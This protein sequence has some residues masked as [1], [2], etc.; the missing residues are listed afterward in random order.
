[1]TTMR[2]MVVTLEVDDDEVQER[3]A[4]HGVV[5]L[6]GCERIGALFDFTITTARRE[7][8]GET[9]VRAADLMGSRITVIFT[10]DEQGEVRR[11]HGIVAEVQERGDASI[12]GHNLRLRVVP[13]HFQL[14]MVRTQEIYLE[15]SVPEIVLRKLALHEIES[16]SRLPLLESYPKREFVA[17]H[18]ESDLA[19]ISRLCEH[20]G[21]SFFS[22]H[23]DGRDVLVFV[24]QES[25]FPEVAEPLR[26]AEVTGRGLRELNVTTR[27]VPRHYGV[28][29]YNYRTPNADLLGI[30]ELEPGWVGGVVEYGAHHRDADEGARLAGV[31]A[32][33]SRAGQVVFEGE[34]ELVEVTAGHRYMLD[35]PAHPDARILVTEVEHELTQA[36]GG[37]FGDAS[38]QYRNRFR[39]VP[40]GF[41]YRPPRITP[42]PHIHGLLTGVVQPGPGGTIGGVAQLDAQGRYTVQ[43]HYDAM[44]VD[45][46]RASHP[47]R[48]AQTFTGAD[49]GMHFPLRPG[50]E[51]LLAF[52]GGDPDRPVIVGAVPN[53][54]T[55]SPVT[56]HRPNRNRI[57]T[58]SGVTIEIADG[59]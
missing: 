26:D 7:G 14:T 55:R 30:R 39:G 52:V 41:T 15:M 2:T 31:R 13:T 8:A 38:F 17:Q 51:V 27:L 58:G 43:F 32:E 6:R 45:G 46:V 19:F 4:E 16:S 37:N 36:I 53:T 40:A 10:D 18:A 57:T 35:H 56:A 44:N 28:D 48:M 24:D 54:V 42:R 5:A 25:G 49:Q 34:S 23:E 11:L 21:I 12:V 9:T 50:T 33:E 29:D 1:M 3:L 22:V 20:V 59:R 47:V